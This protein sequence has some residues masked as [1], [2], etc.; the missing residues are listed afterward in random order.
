[1]RAENHTT[2]HSRYIRI[3]G[4]PGSVPE[5][6]LDVRYRGDAGALKGVALDTYVVPRLISA[7][8]SHDD[9]VE[10]SETLSDMRDAIAKAKGV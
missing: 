1:M 6:V 2:G 3:T 9:L 10:A 4:I 7:F 5:L 8:N